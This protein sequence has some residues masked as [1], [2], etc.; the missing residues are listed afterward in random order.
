MLGPLSSSSAASPVFDLKLRGERNLTSKDGASEITGDS[1]GKQ[2]LNWLGTSTLPSDPTIIMIFHGLMGIAYNKFGFCEV[3]IHSKSPDHEFRIIVADITSDSPDLLYSH[4]FGRAENSPPD[5]IRFD[6]SGPTTDGISFYMPPGFERDSK[7][8]RVAAPG[9][10]R[11]ILD[12]EGPDFYDR[13][14]Q[15]KPG[16]FNPRIY[17]KNGTFLA[18]RATPKNFKRI[19]P[20][21]SLELGKIVQYVAA[22][23]DLNKDGFASLRIGSAEVKLNSAGGKRYAVV[24]DNSCP[25]AD[26]EFKPYSTKK[27][28]RNDFYLYGDSFE[29]PRDLEEYELVISDYTLQTS[30]KCAS[31]SSGEPFV[32]EGSKTFE[33]KYFPWLDILLGP[34][35]SNNEAP[36]GAAGFGRSDGLGGES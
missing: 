12:L 18:V 14:L 5:I 6:V 33:A 9:D 19:A 24:F 29:I 2:N 21:N 16:V 3:G 23:I 1:N 31:E 28:K 22:C 35:N 26:C 36:C 8:G 15:K 30:A 27:E 34:D 13:E 20:N 10:F 17:F 32:D 25:P 4:K 11:L 7:D